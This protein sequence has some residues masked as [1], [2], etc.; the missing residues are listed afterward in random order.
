M[1]NTVY[2]TLTKGLQEVLGSEEDLKKICTARPLNI[3]WGTAPTGRIHIGYMIPFL[4]II[5][6]LKVNSGVTILLADLHAFLDSKKTTLELLD[7]R[8]EYY[9]KIIRATLISL[10][11]DIT[12]LMFVRGTSYQLSQKYTMDMYKMASMTS[13]GDAKHAGAEVVKQSDN[14]LMTGLIYPLLQALDEEYLQADVQMGG[15]DQRKIFVFAR[16]NMPK[17]GYKKRFHFMTPMVPGLRTTKK[18]EVQKKDITTVD[19]VKDRIIELMSNTD[20]RNTLLYEID[21]L[22]KKEQEDDLIQMEKMSSSNEDT[23]IDLLDGKGQL[24]KKIAKAYCLPGD[25]EDNTSLDLLEMIVFPIL[26]LK[27]KQFEISRKEEHGGT[28][29]YD[30]YQ[31]VRDDFA[32]S[33]LHPAD[34]KSGLIDALDEILTPIRDVFADRESQK[35]LMKAYPTKK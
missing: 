23:K 13:L 3:Y 34:L 5:D 21:Q 26:R 22:V 14:P 11:A 27:G 18:D 29:F 6:F 8:S 2:G 7:A 24:K 17:V 15:V 1:A 16:E 10:G 12:K 31:Q 33:K 25:A 35:L 4:K 20:N 32:A 19:S 30:N 28:L 9:E